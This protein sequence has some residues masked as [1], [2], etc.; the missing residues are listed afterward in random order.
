VRWIQEKN[1]I[2]QTSIIVVGEKMDHE[3]RFREAWM[4]MIETGC[5]YDFPQEFLKAI[6][7]LFDADAIEIDVRD[8]LI[9]NYSETS[10]KENEVG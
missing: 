6:D 4:Q 7:A 1:C 5:Y 9:S 8:E 2:V 10:R 3:Q